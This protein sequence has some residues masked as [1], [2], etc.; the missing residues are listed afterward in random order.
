MHLA[1]EPPLFSSF[2]SFTRNR[3]IKTLI[4][5]QTLQQRCRQL[6]RPGFGSVNIAHIVRS[7]V[8]INLTV[9]PSDMDKLGLHLSRKISKQIPPCII[10][11]PYTILT[12]VWVVD[13]LDEFDLWRFKGIITGKLYGE[14]VDAFKVRSA[15]VGRIKWGQ[16]LGSGRLVMIVLPVLEC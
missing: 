1:V 10:P 8:P 3:A 9:L 14:K 15:R 5:S 16:Y 11:K 2:T 13:W 12:D 4:Y 7:T 6:N